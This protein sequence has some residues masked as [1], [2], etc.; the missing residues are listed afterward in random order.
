MDL[1]ISL[2]IYDW[3]FR[4]MWWYIPIIVI[5]CFIYPFIGKKIRNTKEDK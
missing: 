2:Q 1:P 5:V 4:Q 3:W